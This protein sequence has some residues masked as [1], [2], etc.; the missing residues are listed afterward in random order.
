MSCPTARAPS[1][2]LRHEIVITAE[3]ADLCRLLTARGALVFGL[4]DKPDEASL[5]TPQAAQQGYRAIH[6]TPMKVYGERVF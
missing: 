1:R 3:V 6:D 2:C 4:S 5:P